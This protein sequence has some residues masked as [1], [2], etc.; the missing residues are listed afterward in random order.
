M[1]DR[2]TIGEVAK[3]AG[4]TTKTVRHYHEIGLLSEPER[5][6]SGYRLYAA[7]DL[8]RL[9]RIRRLRSFGLSLK[10]IENI[11][12]ETGGEHS[13]REALEALLAEV[14]EEM[15]KLDAR[16]RRLEDLLAQGD[17]A[18]TGEPSEDPYAIK[19]AREYLGDHLSEVSG[20]LWEQERS[21]WASLDTFEWPE[22]YRELQ[23]L[24]I[25]YY[26]DRPEEYREMLGISERLASLAELPEG[27][28][29]VERVAEDL[30]RHLEQTPIP[31]NP[32]SGSPL[33]SNPV[34]EV[35]SEVVLA[36]LSPAQRRVIELAQ[37]YFEPG[38]EL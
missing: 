16:R 33:A 2:L 14:S 7:N 34:V 28:H 35:F 13:L 10:R 11:L 31:D 20:E 36:N 6:E 8:L 12:G 32:L 9:Q 37:K 30:A 29:E 21:M 3:L 24:I 25:F 5:S 18:L 26:A 17:E 15:D 1:R 19:L 22:G 38:G 4:V 23:Q 27:S